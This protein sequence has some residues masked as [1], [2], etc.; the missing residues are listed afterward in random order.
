MDLFEFLKIVFESS[1]ERFG[2]IKALPMAICT[3][4]KAA[5]LLDSVEIGTEGCVLF[6]RSE[7]PEGDTN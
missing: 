6:L 7:V 3:D 2:C 4:G 5:Y 1:T